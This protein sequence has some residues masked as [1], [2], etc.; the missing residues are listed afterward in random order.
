MTLAAMLAELYRRGRYAST[1]ATDVTTR[2]T[3]FLNEVQ[4][5]IAGDVRLASLRR[6]ETTFATTASQAEYGLSPQI[7]RITTIR[8]TTNRWPLRYRSLEWYRAAYPNQATQNGTPDSYVELGLKP[9]KLQPAAA[10]GV[11][12]ASTSAG[13][14]TQT[15]SLEAIRTG[16][17]VH[18]PSVTTLTGTSRVQLGAQT[19]YIEIIDWYLSATP[20]GD[21]TLF[22]AA[23]SGNV[24]GVIPKGQT[25]VTYPWIA[26]APTPSASLT[27][28]LDYERLITDLAVST[29]EPAWI[30]PMFHRILPI[31]ARWKEYEYQSDDRVTQAIQQYGLVLSQLVAY[32][33]NPPGA[34][35][36]PGGYRSGRS[37]L[38]PNYPAGTVWD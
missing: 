2:L 19:D 10:T 16:G 30:P 38:G 37:D 32:T 25:R 31:G 4:Q 13:D 24:L 7:G 26:F 11:W 5:E 23:A 35:L 22:D 6:G 34:I 14:T 8:D 27:Y 12:A 20:A 21:V 9:V 3:G 15:V 29:D 33:N 36:V 1:P 18:L 28:S 17:Y